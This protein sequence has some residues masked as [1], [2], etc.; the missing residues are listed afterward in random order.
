MEGGSGAH[1]DPQVG[2]GLQGCLGTLFGIEVALVPPQRFWVVGQW[3]QKS[4]GD[5]TPEKE[6][7]VPDWRRLVWQP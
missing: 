5:F 7:G 1:G 6:D 4:P 3:I 2:S